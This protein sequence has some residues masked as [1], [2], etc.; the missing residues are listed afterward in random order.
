MHLRP[1]QTCRPQSRWMQV[2]CLRQPHPIYPA[3][4]T[5]PLN[6][7]QVSSQRHS[8]LQKL[9]QD[10]V[11]DR[12]PFTAFE[13]EWMSAGFLETATEANFLS[14]Y[15]L[16]Y[17]RFLPM[18]KS[19]PVILSLRIYCLVRSSAFRCQGTNNC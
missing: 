8:I 19:H 1:L 13:N 16:H 12:D 18:F 5:H 11:P 17:Q 9:L 4:A 2:N 6:D 14:S 7:T 10:N 15:R 3:P